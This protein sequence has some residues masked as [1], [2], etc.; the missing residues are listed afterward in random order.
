[1]AD[2]LNPDPYSLATYDGPKAG[3]QLFPD[4]GL[5]TAGQ[6]LSQA[7][8]Q[9]F[10]GMPMGWNNPTNLYTSY[11]AQ[12]KLTQ[13]NKRMQSM[14][15][16]DGGLLARGI[17]SGFRLT[18]VKL[19]PEQK[20]E[21]EKAGLT[22]Y[23]LVAPLL[24]QTDEGTRILDTVTGGESQLAMGKFTSDFARRSYDPR[25]G[26]YG[27]KN[28]TY[29]RMTKHL[30]DT[31]TGDKRMTRAAGLSSGEIG[32]LTREL[33]S[34][35]MIAGPEQGL[36]G[37]AAMASQMTNIKR[38]LDD[39][40]KAI[41]ALKEIFGAAGEPNAPLPKLL[42]AL[43]AMTGGSQQISGKRL[44]GIA[45]GI[46]N[47]ADT[48]GIGLQQ[49][50]A[51]L[52]MNSKMLTSQGLN[53]A[54][55]API[56]QSQMLTHAA[57][58]QTGALQ[59]SS[60][61]LLNQAQLSGFS[62]AQET[63]AIGSTTA[64]LLGTIA[65][66]K[67]QGVAFGTGKDAKLLQEF[68]NEAQAG[69]MGK[70]TKA[71]A[72]MDSAKQAQLLASGFGISAQVAEDQLRARDANMEHIYGTNAQGHVAM[73][74]VLEFGKLTKGLTS[75]RIS[76]A[77]AEGGMK[78]AG[79]AGKL[80][81][82]LSGHLY[83]TLIG[84][85]NATRNDKAKRSAAL[86][87]SAKAYLQANGGVEAAGLAGD[88]KALNLMVNDVYNR[89]NEAF[90]GPDGR[91][92]SLNNFLTINAPEVRAARDANARRNKIIGDME[93]SVAGANQSK[94]MRL[95]DALLSYGQK[96][97]QSG[98][99]TIFKALNIKSPDAVQGDAKKM[100]AGLMESRQKLYGQ[101]FED[102]GALKV[103]FTEESAAKGLRGGMESINKELEKWIGGDKDRKAI[104]EDL[105][106][107]QKMEDKGAGGGPTSMK[108]M[109]EK[110]I[111]KTA[112]G[113]E[114][115]MKDAESDKTDATA[116]K[117]ESVDS[118]DV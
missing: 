8:A 116:K 3:P 30:M 9:Y 7:A 54:F 38:A 6:L 51:F 90:K 50:S 84:M 26:S 5:G 58:G 69:V 49:A 29:E 52:D 27:Y 93:S 28:E 102:N 113:K 94:G 68:S 78:D 67:D 33:G 105:I 40:V 24:T 73:M 14:A 55:A 66:L 77:L 104:V 64:N 86:Q 115:D 48:A 96:A 42:N 63:R 62:A 97:D 109:I 13:H 35:G 21:M 47:A 110:L 61:G 18:D 19:S 45:R 36:K 103:G 53:A 56:T 22:A 65:R 20:K 57:L 112:G 99:E 91:G 75:G 74:Q 12:Q 31:Y 1:M 43:E 37:E 100:F 101:F 59:T 111:L 76:T 114:L 89:M 118:A 17:Q 117:A 4:L 44:E 83:E 39:K 82:D 16:M 79:K 41:A 23:G 85:D 2:F 15:A 60:W 32:E 80:S 70:A 106:S 98:V 108:L 92:P 34:R 88:D 25:T 11:A 81:Q 71:L 72:G 87:V 107:K 10:G 46:K 95:A